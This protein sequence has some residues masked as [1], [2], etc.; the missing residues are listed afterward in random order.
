MGDGAAHD[1]REMRGRQL[2]VLVLLCGVLVACVPARTGPGE[3]T[4]RTAT[5][6]LLPPPTV[7]YRWSRNET[8]VGA[9]VISL[10]AGPE[11]C[12]MQS[13]LFL[14]FHRTLGAP[15]RS[16]AD[17][18]E[19][20]RDPT[21]RWAPGASNIGWSTVGRFAPSIPRPANALFTGYVNAHGMELWRLP[22]ESAWVLLRRGDT[23]EQWPASREPVGCA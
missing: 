20:V 23:W 14:R 15:L 16:F 17:A 9:D 18:R 11:H 1:Q 7:G 22:T 2:L 12:E 6:T 13:I 4:P 19:Y 3:A 8:Q 21:N 10:D 5:A